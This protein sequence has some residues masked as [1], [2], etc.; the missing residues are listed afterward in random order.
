M[1]SKFSALFG[2]VP[3]SPVLVWVYLVFACGFEVFWAL[4]L[5]LTQ[6][7]THSGWTIATIPLAVISTGFL[8]LAMKGIQMGTAYA[9]W[10]GVGAVGTATIGIL[11][12][13]E[14]A[15]LA[16]LGCIG[17]ILLGVAGLKLAQG[18]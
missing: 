14:P 15:G 12:F 7:Y 13:S 10:T 16:R 5:K 18:Q 2:S 9:V 6:G 8:A 11:Y 1:F 17:L 3:T 4:S